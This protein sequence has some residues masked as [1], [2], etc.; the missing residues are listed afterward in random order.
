MRV[1]GR[2]DE[3]VIFR[4]VFLYPPDQCDP[5]EPGE[6]YRERNDRRQLRPS[7]E[8]GRFKVAGGHSHD[9]VQAQ[10]RSMLWTIEFMLRS[11][12]RSSNIVAQD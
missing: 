1:R 6:R 2:A 3:Q 11:G 4:R 12:I 7:P 10:T 5:G 9:S 8:Q